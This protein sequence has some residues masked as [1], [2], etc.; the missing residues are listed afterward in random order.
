MLNTVRDHTF[1]TRPLEQRGAVVLDLGANFGDFSQTIRRRY[2]CECIAVEPNDTCR[3]VVSE[4]L[5]LPCLPYALTDTCGHQRFRIDTDNPEASRLA[6]D[7]IEVETITLD[8]LLIQRRLERVALVKMD[9]E[10]AEIPVLNSLT[11]AVASKIDQIAVEFHP[12]DL[13]VLHDTLAHV[14]RLGFLIL[15]FSRASYGDTLLVNRA[16]VALNARELL[17]LRHLA[18]PYRGIGRIMRRWVH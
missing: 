13:R 1:L 12:V 15:P 7:G 17:Y 2:A 8:A 10:G 18:R 9:I 11:P 14:R 4:F 16:R 5:A 3:T 6:A